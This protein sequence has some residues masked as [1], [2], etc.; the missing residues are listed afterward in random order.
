MDRY[1]EKASG[2]EGKGNKIAE[3]EAIPLEAKILLGLDEGQG[4]PKFYFYG[5]VNK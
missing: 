2:R 4:F 3:G 5:P 1:T